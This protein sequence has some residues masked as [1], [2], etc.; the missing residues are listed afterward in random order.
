MIKLSYSF[1][2]CEVIGNPTTGPADVTKTSFDSITMGHLAL[3][4]N[5]PSIYKFTAFEIQRIC[6]SQLRQ[7][8]TDSYSRH[9]SNF[10][11]KPKRRQIRKNRLD[12]FGKF[13]LSAHLFH[14]GAG[15]RRMHQPV[16]GALVLSNI[17]TLELVSYTLWVPQNFA[18]D[19]HVLV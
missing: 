10:G 13:I 2:D 12:V 16:P 5:S 6:L 7:T 1:P 17:P 11:Y 19:Q 14:Q 18:S 4:R 3:G 8:H 15:K 9:N